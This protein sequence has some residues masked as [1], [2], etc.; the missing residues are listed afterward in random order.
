MATTALSW[1]PVALDPRPRGNGHASDYATTAIVEP[2]WRC[3]EASPKNPAT[4]VA[5]DNPK[6]GHLR[7][8]LWASVDGTEPSWKPH[9]G[10]VS[11]GGSAQTPL[12]A[13]EGGIRT[14]EGA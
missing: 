1:S 4:F 13:E 8:S 7:G 12:E 14:L 2:A 6:P 11:A 5:L 9:H 10:R 3:P